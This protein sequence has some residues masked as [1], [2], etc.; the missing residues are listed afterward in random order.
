M[1]KLTPAQR[2]FL[3]RLAVWGPGPAD[4]TYSPAQKMLKAGY[5]TKEVRRNK[6]RLHIFTITEAGRA[7]LT[8]PKTGG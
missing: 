7:A 4:P 6:M 1:A 3:N 8:N 2:E 5:V